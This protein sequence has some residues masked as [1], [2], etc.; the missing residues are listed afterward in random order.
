MRRCEGRG[1]DNDE[2]VLD[3]ITARSDEAR[4]GKALSGGVD[5]HGEGYMCAR[6]F[7]FQMK[8]TD[9]DEG[10]RDRNIFAYSTDFFFLIQYANCYVASEEKR[11]QKN[12]ATAD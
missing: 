9:D 12:N 6:T 3:V 5:I 4:T 2:S 8:R 1:R 7:I 11:R 10:G